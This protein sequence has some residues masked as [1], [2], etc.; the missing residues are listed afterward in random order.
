MT[1][2]STSP[3]RRNVL[4]LFG[5]AGAGL[6]LSGM[7]PFSAH[8]EVA[9]PAQADLVSGDRATTMW[10]PAPA[11]ESRIIEQGLPIGN[12]R[13]GALVGGDPADDFFYVTDATLW[14]GD[15]N[16]QLQDD[17]QFPYERVHFGTFALLAKVRV[18]VPGHTDV[19]NYRRQLDLSN[20]LVNASYDHGGA[21]YQREVYAS[22]PD[23]VVVI[24]LTQRGGGSYTGTVTLA[25]TH[26]E[27]TAGEPSTGTAAFAGVLGNGLKYAAAIKASGNRGTVAVKGTQ[28]EFTNCAEVVIVV[29]GGTDYAPDVTT[30]Y[31]LPGG[32]PLGVARTKAR[33]AAAVA[34]AVLLN[35]HVVDYHRLYNKM[36]VDLGSSSASQ[37]ALDSWSRL[38][39]LHANP[40]IPDPELEASYLQFGRYLTITGSRG[41]LPTGLQGLWLNNNEPDWM[42]DYHT[43]VNLEMNYWLPDRAGLSCAFDAY[44]DYVLAQLPSWT[45]TTQ[46]LFNDPR[47]RFRN[48]SG[49][50]G[51]WTVAI[52]TNTNGGGGWWWHP[53]GNAWLCNSLWQHYEYLQD[54]S[55]LKKIY[56]ALKG[57]CE[58]W[59]ARLIAMTVDGREVLVDD[60][61]WS[62]E[63]GPQDALGITYAQELVW[64]LFEHYRAASA[65]LNKDKSYADTI[66]AMQAKLYLP[67][68]SPTSGWLEEWMSPDNL[69]ETTHRHL[70]PLIG[71][72][73]GD[74]LNT[75]T[76]SPAL[77]DG[78]RK[79]LT[80]R[81]MDSF[82]WACAWRALCWA[83]LK[84]GEL[85][86]QLVRTVLRPSVENGNGTAANF[87]DMYSQNTYAIFQI[88]ANFGTPAAMI[89]MLLYSR[90]GVIEL[91]P[92]LPKAWA[93]NGEIT[94]I[95]ARGGFEVDL[96]WKAGKVT[97]ATVRSVGGTTTELRG[98]GWRTKITLR[99]GQSV[100]IRR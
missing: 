20:G 29:S 59:E 28:I 69:G 24:R 30:G 74:R 68:V 5:A 9:R 70:S 48:T 58:F 32:N 89:E 39:A 87:F 38:T 76:S 10:Y 61:D 2:P 99:P 56:A 65:L 82:G 90:P 67:K 84:D 60:H 41:S 77:L 40:T 83:R 72:F 97:R 6:A 94:G 16:D 4:K 26:G 14:T 86:Y 54:K 66:R 96:A 19:R 13:L 62:P 50:I 7:R 80:A 31:R 37:R 100:T 75:D 95:G 12:G 15:A 71:F 3:S 27:S 92:A 52:S 91:L 36:K 18:A 17:G 8:A 98:E 23:D 33:T 46:N 51:G 21:H 47:N 88:D 34:G 42:G 44:A 55:Y 63:Q 81:G 78:V 35:T 53:A 43:D 25:G 73:P 11:D 45:T 22:Y 64:D 1:F 85:A 93:Q 79:L 49:K 57:A